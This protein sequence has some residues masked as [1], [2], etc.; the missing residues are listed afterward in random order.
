M[1]LFEYCLLKCDGD[2]DE[3]QAMLDAMVEDVANGADPDDT[4]HD[5]GIEPDWSIELIGLAFD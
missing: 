4:L 2:K 1:T 5:N 3:A